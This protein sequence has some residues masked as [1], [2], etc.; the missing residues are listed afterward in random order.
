MVSSGSKGNST[1]V[2]DQ[3]DAIIVDFGISVRR[4]RTRIRETGISHERFSAVISHEHSDH[5]S[6]LSSLAKGL[7]VDIYARKAT[8]EALPVS[9]Y[10]LKDSM[11]IGNFKISAIS[12]SHDAADPVAFIIEN[13]SARIGI[14]SDLGTYDQ[15]LSDALQGS[16]I[17]AV[18]ANHDEQMLREG[19]Y[20]KFLKD[21][22]GGKFGHLSNLQS[23]QL[24][25][26]TAS[27]E[28]RI[29]LTHLSQENNRPELALNTVRKHLSSWNVQFRSIECASQESGTPIM[30]IDA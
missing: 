23:A 5:S 13:G 1:L 27:H 11:V 17:L 6:G 15:R 21:R 8:S 2:W 4:L 14:V 12:V 18:E 19:S 9:C 30:Y 24:L 3:D 29:I 26:E 16:D 22:I 7:N 20:P 10:S 25:N 28:S